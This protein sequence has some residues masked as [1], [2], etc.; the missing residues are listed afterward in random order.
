MK[1]ARPLHGLACHI[2][3]NRQHCS[4]SSVPRTLAI[5]ANVFPLSL[6]GST[7]RL[8]LSASSAVSLSFWA[9]S[10]FLRCASCSLRSRSALFSVDSGFRPR[11]MR[12]LQQSLP[13][14]QW[15][16][17]HSINCPVCTV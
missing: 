3:C 1:L 12:T 9:A 4:S 8:T 13:G 2:T 11:L 14:H 16:M 7:H 5:L 10:C 17:L 6:A 15:T